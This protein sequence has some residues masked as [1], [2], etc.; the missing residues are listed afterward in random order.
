MGAIVIWVCDSCGHR[1]DANPRDHR[2]G[3]RLEDD[4]E[5]PPPLVL[6]AALVAQVDAAQALGWTVT[7]DGVWC[8][9]HG[10]LD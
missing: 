1:L 2:L 6:A 10:A 8:P 4:Q 7:A 9:D 5:P 3:E